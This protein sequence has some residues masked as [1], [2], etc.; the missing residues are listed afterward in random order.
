MT[1]ASTTWIVRRKRQARP[2]RVP[3]LKAGK[4][5]CRWVSVCQNTA[6]ANAQPRVLLAWLAD[7]QHPEREELLNWLGE[8]FDPEAFD[9]AAVN[10]LLT[11]VKL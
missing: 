11:R 5:L 9:L 6:S 7:P 10:F 2:L 3:R 8:P 1:V 4:V